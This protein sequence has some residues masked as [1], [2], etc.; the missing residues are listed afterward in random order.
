MNDPSEVAATLSDV[1]YLCAQTNRFFPEARL[2]PGDVIATGTTDANGRFNLS[3]S[4]GDPKVWLACDDTCSKPDVRV[5]IDVIA[6][7]P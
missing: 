5:E 2:G 4:G 7:L 3:G 6:V 1:E